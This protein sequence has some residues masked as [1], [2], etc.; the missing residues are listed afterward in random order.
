MGNKKTI[1]KKLPNTTI[2]LQNVLFL[3]YFVQIEFL[4]SVRF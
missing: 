2:V 1:C 3:A 4:E